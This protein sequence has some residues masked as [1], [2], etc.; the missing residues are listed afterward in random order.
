M[1]SGGS[2]SQAVA[3]KYT[4]VWDSAIVTFLVAKF[5]ILREPKDCSSVRFSVS[6]LVSC[7]RKINGGSLFAGGVARSLETSEG[8]R[9][10]GTLR[11]LHHLLRWSHC[12]D[13]Q[14]GTTTWLSTCKDIRH[15]FEEFG[16]FVAVYNKVPIE[17]H[18]T[19]F[20]TVKELFDLPLEVKL[21]NTS[22]KPFYGYRGQFGFNP[23]F[24]SLGIDNPTTLERTQSFTELMWPEGNV[25]FCKS[26][27]SITK[28]IEE[29]NETVIRMLFESYGVEKYA[30]S[31]IRSMDYLLRAFGYGVPKENESSVV[32]A[33]SHADMSLISILYQNLVNGL[34]IKTKDDEWIDVDLS[35]SSFL[36]LAGD[37]IMAWSN[38]RILHCYH[39]VMLRTKEA[40]YSLG[41]FAAINGTIQVPEEL[42]DE[43]HPLK[44]KSF[45]HFD[46]FRRVLSEKNMTPK[47][48]LKEY[49]GV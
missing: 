40:R 4:K 14:H 46:Y 10:R 27:L 9:S 25:R 37:G 39:K 43:E 19:L 20:S 17:L 26:V 34:Q 41:L 32:G 7:R 15:A 35:P 21:K 48:F 38:D 30:D 16:C 28:T 12:P 29:L 44:Y 1:D 13:Q 33:N 36:V 24:E 3:L 45:E 47:C 22:D 2:D 31:Y 6:I 23:L 8:V 18:K 5:K 49:Y 11:H 42:Q